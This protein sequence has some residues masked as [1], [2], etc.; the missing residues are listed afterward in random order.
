[1]AGRPPPGY[2]DAVRMP[3][4]A[5]EGYIPPAVCPVRRLPAMHFCLVFSRGDGTAHVCCVRLPSSRLPAGQRS[6]APG[7]APQRVPNL[8]RA[9]ARGAERRPRAGT[10]SQKSIYNDIIQ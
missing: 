1:M 3:G 10:N 7:R 8:F 5:Y 9:N 2:N 4:R 6:G